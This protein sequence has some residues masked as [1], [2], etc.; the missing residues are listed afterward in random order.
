[1]FASCMICRSGVSNVGNG[2]Q[3]WEEEQETKERGHMAVEA[4]KE[5]EA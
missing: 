2:C 5:E 3:S 1:M 4:G